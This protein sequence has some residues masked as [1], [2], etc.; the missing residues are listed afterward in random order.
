MNYPK[1][2]IEANE[3]LRDLDGIYPGFTPNDGKF[4]LRHSTELI[5]LIPDY[6]DKGDGT[7]E[8]IY[9]MVCI[10]GRNKTIHT[11]RC[12]RKGIVV[13]KMR[14][15]RVSTFGPGGQFSS[16]D[17]I[18]AFCCWRPPISREDWKY[19][20]GT[21]ADY[22]ANGRYIPVHRG[23]LPITVPPKAS[24]EEY[25][26]IA[27]LLVRKLAEHA[28]RWQEEILSDTAKNQ[29]LKVPIYDQFGNVIREPDKDAP[30]WNIKA[31]LAEK[32]RSFNPSG[33]VGY[34]K[35]AEVVQV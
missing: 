30:Y 33:T 25:P 9:D 22:P 15:K 28:D 7:V 10:C 11:R 16:F 24:P 27:R 3:I 21:D 2:V 14:L 1:H 17:N 5:S 19:S 35:K 18:Y 13:A 26:A 23:P 29:K 31:R 4:Q 32:M 6:E 8:P 12:L 34:S 20:M